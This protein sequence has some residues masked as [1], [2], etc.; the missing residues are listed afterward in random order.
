[1]RG[2]RKTRERREVVFTEAE[3]TTRRQPT[4]PELLVD[5]TSGQKSDHWLLQHAE[6]LEAGTRAVSEESGDGRPAWVGLQRMA[7]K[8]ES[9]M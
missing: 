8:E 2:E 5:P 1:M 9:G 4:I 3:R 7:V 6:W